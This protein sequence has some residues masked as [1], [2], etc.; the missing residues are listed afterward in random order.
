MPETEFYQGTVITLDEADW[1]KHAYSQEILDG[2]AEIVREHPQ[3]LEKTDVAELAWS[4]YAEEVKNDP[5]FQRD[6]QSNSRPPIPRSGLRAYM[7]DL[8]YDPQTNSMG[9]STRR[10]LVDRI[11]SYIPFLR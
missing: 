6:V 8:F 2:C 5:D 4:V 1:I 10:S 11:R 3:V 7:E 9:F